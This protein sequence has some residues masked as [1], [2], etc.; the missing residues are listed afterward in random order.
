MQ[1]NCRTAVLFGHKASEIGTRVGRPVW[2][3]YIRITE[4]CYIYRVCK[5]L[6][7]QG[8]VNTMTGGQ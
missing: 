7:L 2:Y 4:Y 5:V 1:S 6:P 8:R 3:E